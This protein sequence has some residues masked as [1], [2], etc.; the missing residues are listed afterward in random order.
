MQRIVA[1][2]ANQHVRSIAPLDDKAD[3][4]RAAVR[5]VRDQFVPA[6]DGAVRELHPVETRIRPFSP[7]L[8]GEERLRPADVQE[9]IGAV[10]E[11]ARLPRLRGHTQ[12]H[13]AA[14]PVQRID[15][16]YR[17]ICAG[18]AER[19]VVRAGRTR[20]Q[21]CVRK[22]AAI[23][24]LEIVDGRSA[25]CR[26]LQSDGVAVGADGEPAAV[27][28][29]HVP[30]DARTKNDPVGRAGFVLEN[31]QIVKVNAGQYMSVDRDVGTV[32]D[33]VAAIAEIEQISVV[34]VAAGQVVVAC[35]ARQNVVTQSAGQCVIAIPAI[36]CIGAVA[37][38][39]CIGPGVA[40]QQI[41]PAAAV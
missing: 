37:A 30:R 15:D 11:H 29:K 27:E 38:V 23:G 3:R 31:P 21:L 24:K 26:R 17:L 16:V 41:V 20:G 36:Q 39:K 10:F 1:V 12:R 7:A 25:A 4:V 13:R 18:A 9:D 32:R 22:Y 19:I 5:G 28:N 6:P 34:A 35:A 33:N 14:V 40:K 8:D 2:A